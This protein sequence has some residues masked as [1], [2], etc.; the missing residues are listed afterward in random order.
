MTA[1]Q[2]ITSVV[3]ALIAAGLLN[4]FRDLIKDRKDRK[5]A[6]TPE[7][8]AAAHVVNVDHSLVVVAKARDELEADNARI[9]ETLIEQRQQHAEDRERWAREKA[10]M[11]EE[12]DVLE[13]KLRGAGEYIDSLLAELVRIRDRH[14]DPEK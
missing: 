1:L 11:R 3:V 2:A 5:N 9:R 6:A 12:I 4:W 13:A 8:R 7:G 10:Q 14:A